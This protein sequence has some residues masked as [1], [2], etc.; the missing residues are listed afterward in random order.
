MKAQLSSIWYQA[1]KIIKDNPNV[2][3]SAYEHWIEPLLPVGMTEEAIYLKVPTELHLEIVKSM[4]FDTIQSAILAASERFYNV[5]LLD[6]NQPLPAELEYTVTYNDRDEGAIT[7]N[8]K[9]SFSS[10]VVGDSNRLA[11]AASQAVSERP[12]DAFNPLFIYGGPGLGK[13]HLVQ[14]IGN[15]I[16][17]KNP[18]A[19]IVYVTSE[20]FT[21]DFINTLLDKKTVDFRN[22]YRTCD[23][24]IVDDI[25]FISN[26]DQTQIEFFHTFNTLHEANKQIIITS[27]R[28]PREIKELEERM[29]TRF[30]WGLIV[31]IKQPDLETRVAILKKKAS[32]ENFEV[33]D[34]ILFYIAEHLKSNI[35]NLEGV[36]KRLMAYNV[37]MG[38]P[39][40]MQLADE[41][42]KE[43]LNKSDDPHV[44]TEYILSIVSNYFGVTSDEI[45][46]SKRT[47]EI[48]YARHIAMY[49]MREFTGQSLPEIGKELGGRNHATVLNG[50]NNIKNSM[51]KNEDTKKIVEELVTNL[52]NRQ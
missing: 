13:T 37:L 50:I 17:E 24:L 29:R 40:T 36:L 5:E 25:Q 22:K 16:K 31:D 14:A 8:P 39:I 27:D 10:F 9:Y 20:K 51:E 47:K 43:F 46:S 11:H 19:N 12:A 45:L 48:A 15:E 33:P 32:E 26:K 30:E 34:D 41:A 6:Y 28:P 49:L 23:V 18:M 2:S 21:N 3:Q 35:R 1:L 44:N 4:H 42:I 38:K 7:L 52:E